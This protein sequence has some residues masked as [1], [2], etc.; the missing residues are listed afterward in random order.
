MYKISQP[1]ENACHIEYIAMCVYQ[2]IYMLGFSLL[3]GLHELTNGVT[4]ILKI[5]IYLIYRTHFMYE[6]R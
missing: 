5:Y 4:A 6:H 1:Q 2:N 3:F